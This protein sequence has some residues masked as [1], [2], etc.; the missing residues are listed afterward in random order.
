MARLIPSAVDACA[1]TFLP[2]LFA[3]LTAAVELLERRPGHRFAVRTP[4]IVRVDLDPVG[5][6]LD[7]V[8][9]DA[10]EASTPFASSAPCGMSF[11]YS[12]ANPFGAYWPVTTMAFVDA[13]IRGPGMM[14]CAI[15]SLRPTSAYPAPSVPRSR[16]LVNPAINCARAWF[17]ARATRRA[18]CS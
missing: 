12:V 2:E 13:H 7:L 14:P 15:A 8:A 6:V 11:I 5:A 10:D 4:A 16:A 9:H 18:S 1:A 17:T 3:T